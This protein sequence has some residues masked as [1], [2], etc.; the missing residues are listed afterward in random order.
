MFTLLKHVYENMFGKFLYIKNA[1]AAKHQYQEMKTFYF[2]V[3]TGL[4]FTSLTRSKFY[5]V[6]TKGQ[7]APITL[8]GKFQNQFMNCKHFPFYISLE[9]KNFNLLKNVI[10]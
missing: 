3:L 8:A 1:L 4:F 6:E 7:D 2:I 10:L 5:L 9:L